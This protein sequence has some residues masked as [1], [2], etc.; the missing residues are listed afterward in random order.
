MT[1]QSMN[2]EMREKKKR[3]GQIAIFVVVTVIAVLVLVTHHSKRSGMHV[4][5]HDQKQRP[6]M[7]TGALTDFTESSQETSLEK[8]QMGIKSLQ[9]KL[10]ELTKKL[11]E[12]HQSAE[13]KDALNKRLQERVIALSY[14]AKVKASAAGYAGNTANQP[15]RIVM[16]SFSFNYPHKNT[17]DD[18][19]SKDY[20]AS[21]TYVQGVL[22]QGADANASVNGQSATQAI[23]IKLTGNGVLP[24]GKK[25]SLKGCRV[26][27]SIYGDISSERG[28]VR[29]ISLSC[30]RKNGDIIDV[31]ADGYVSFH[32]KEGIAGRPVMRNGKIIAWAGL[33]GLMSGF[34]NALSQSNQKTQQTPLGPISQLKTGRVWSSAG[35]QGL[36][37]AMDKL[38]T[39]YIKR[40]D[41]YH[42]IIEIGSG[43]KLTVVFQHGF[44]L[45]NHDSRNV[46]H[47]QSSNAY[48]SSSATGT[49]QGVA[50]D[51]QKTIGGNADI[52]LTAPPSNLNQ[53][54]VPQSIIDKAKQVQLGGQ[55]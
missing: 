13:N 29:T 6:A 28:T 44:Y 35:A 50:N 4:S 46:D 54:K 51:F 32:G 49:G 26:I 31:P 9:S 12:Y 11:D 48:V 18:E 34:G 20:V 30:T 36:G 52:N 16:K 43:N 15:R 8:Q 25:S 38:A 53:F 24:N 40:A 37:S 5:Q 22:L 27:G 2:K 17:G 23:L 3:S 19:N 10:G 45:K 55:L 41:Q 14:K 39:Y 47:T 21:G 42:P 1:N 33:S 7:I